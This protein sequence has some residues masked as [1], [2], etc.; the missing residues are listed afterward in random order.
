MITVFIVDD[1]PVVAQGIAMILDGDEQLQFAGAASGLREAITAV[2]RFK[3]DVV[4][5]D[6]RLPG[7]DVVTGVEAL[8][9]A[10]PT[11]RILL[12]TADPEHMQVR[13]ARAA[14]ALATLAKD[15]PPARLRRFIRTVAAGEPLD[16]DTDDPGVLTA[17]QYDVLARVATG[18]TNGEIAEQLGLQPTTVKTYWQETMQR[19]GVRNRAEAIAAAY[20]RGLL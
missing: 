20:R 4:L 16:G 7:T 2:A 3:P 8:I 18:M 15:T 5:L 14:G 11:V 1:H 12:F 17:R 6:V 19:L 13:N 10:A 9:R